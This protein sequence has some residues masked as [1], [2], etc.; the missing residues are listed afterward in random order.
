MSLIYS[1][2]SRVSE[3]PMPMPSMSKSSPMEY[4]KDLSSTRGGV[5]SFRTPQWLLFLLTIHQCQVR[6]L[7]ILDKQVNGRPEMTSQCFRK[8]CSLQSGKCPIG[9]WS[10]FGCL[11]EQSTGKRQAKLVIDG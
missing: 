9:P 6:M 10:H 2:L 8:K 5:A 1:L 4:A 11:N 3:R 7:P